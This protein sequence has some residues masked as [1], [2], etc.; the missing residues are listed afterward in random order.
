MKKL[1]CT[2]LTLLALS[3]TKAQTL[4]PIDG[5]ATKRTVALYNNLHQIPQRGILFGQQ[6]ATTMGHIWSSD[7]NDRSDIKEMCGSHPAVIGDDFVGLCSNDPKKVA[8]TKRSL[9]NQIVGTY[10][11]GG[12]TT[13]CWHASNPMIEGDNN[14]TFYWKKAQQRAVEHILPGGKAN[15]R[16]KSWLKNIAECMDEVRDDNGKLIPVIF[17][18]LHEFDGDWFWWG[19]SH[20]SKEDFVALWRYTVEQLRDEFGVH[21]ILY[22]FSPD[23][24][25]NNEEELLARYPGDEFVDII[26]FDEYHDFKPS[27]DGNPS[28]ALEKSIIVSDVARK[29]GKIAAMSECGLEGVSDSTWY[30]Q[31]L[32][33]ILKDERVSFAY[34]LVWRNSNYSETHYYAPFKGHPA[35]AD[36]VKF[37]NDQFTIFEDSI[38]KMYK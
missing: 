20:C 1:F 24:R 3:A 27:G 6:D 11:R 22:A 7:T 5:K 10:R 31:T 15:A 36:F 25:F 38:G 26:A 28:K 17:R 32:L 16:Y 34:V 23:C 14:N 2:L 9:V 37:Y 19:E 29:R 8:R 4:K 12:V 21:N 33:P 18:P 30:G 35:E 13:I